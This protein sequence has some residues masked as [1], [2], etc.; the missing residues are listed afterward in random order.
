[1][2][3][4]SGYLQDE[5]DNVERIVRYLQAHGFEVIFLSHSLHPTNIL[6][7]DLEMFR[8]MAERLHVAITSTMEETME[9]YPTLDFVISMRLHAS[10]LSVIYGIPFY[11]ISYGNKTRSIL[12]SLELSFI[13]DAKTFL[14][15]VFRTQF[16]LLVEARTDAEFAIAEKS[17]TMR[18]DINSSLEKLFYGF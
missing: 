4:R 17:D 15:S 2:A 9:L 1:M 14:F 5:S 11:S 3:L 16:W 6:C 12:Q 8:E 13:H 10:I 18:K 7:N